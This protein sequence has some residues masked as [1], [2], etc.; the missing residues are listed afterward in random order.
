MASTPATEARKK[1][2]KKGSISCTAMR[3][4]GK[5]PLKMTTPASPLN[6]PDFRAELVLLTLFLATPDLVQFE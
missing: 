2:R 5:E 3:V 6:Q 1:V 4:A